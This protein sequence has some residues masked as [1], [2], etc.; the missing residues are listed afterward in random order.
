LQAA[1]VV[2]MWYWGARW[3]AFFILSF[4]DDSIANRAFV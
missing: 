4:P 3:N 2:Q 1:R